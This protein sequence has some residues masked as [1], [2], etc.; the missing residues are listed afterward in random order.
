MFAWVLVSS[1]FDT[2][3]IKVTMLSYYT[4]LA[5]QFSSW[6]HEIRTFDMYTNFSL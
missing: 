5:W 6:A 4:S 2:F 3:A 1:P